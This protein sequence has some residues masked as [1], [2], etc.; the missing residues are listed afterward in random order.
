MFFSWQRLHTRSSS[1]VSGLSGRPIK[2]PEKWAFGHQ[3]WSC[4][5]SHCPLLNYTVQVHTAHYI[6]GSVGNFFCNLISMLHEAAQV[7]VRKPHTVTC[8]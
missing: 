4:K 1:S 5:L 6:P 7:A 3:I 2:G 8:S